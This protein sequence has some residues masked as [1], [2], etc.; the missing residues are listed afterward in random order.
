MEGKGVDNEFSFRL[1][2][3]E[4]VLKSRMGAQDFV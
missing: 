1:K 2:R 3:W 4:A